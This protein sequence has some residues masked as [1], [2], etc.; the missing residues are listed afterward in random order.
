MNKDIRLST[1]F[2]DHWKVVVLKTDLGLEAI[3]SL[4]RLWCFT[5]CNKPTGKLSGM[6]VRAIE[7]AAK[8]QGE[9]GVFVDKLLEL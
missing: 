8:W 7:A 4:Q 2:W 9:T 3:E 1:L 5:A 6:N